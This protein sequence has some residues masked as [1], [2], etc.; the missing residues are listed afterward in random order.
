MLPISA[1]IV[2]LL[3]FSH[4][5]LI[6]DHFNLLAQSNSTIQKASSCFGVWIFF[7]PQNSFLIS[8]NCGFQTRIQD[9]CHGHSEIFY[10]DSV[11]FYVLCAPLISQ[12]IYSLLFPIIT[13]ILSE[14]LKVCVYRTWRVLRHFNVDKIFSQE[15]YFD[16]NP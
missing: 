9:F 15:K 2:S 4:I 14:Y 1:S 11:T 12:R 10:R 16:I 3:K 7:S 6:F 5:H 8:L 13:F